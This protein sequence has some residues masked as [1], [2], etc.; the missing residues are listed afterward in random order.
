M[1]EF[2]GD[3]LLPTTER[4]DSRLMTDVAQMSQ[5]RRTRPSLRGWAWTCLSCLDVASVC[6]QTV[7]CLAKTGHSE[8]GTVANEKGV[9]L[10]EVTKDS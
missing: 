3:I 8:G 1:K 6:Q 10:C 9:C 5:K 4:T 7:R 2:K